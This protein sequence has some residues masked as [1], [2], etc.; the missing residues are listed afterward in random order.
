M[1]ELGDS[2]DIGCVNA[3]LEPFLRPRCRRTGRRLLGPRRSDDPRSPTPGFRSGAPARLT[4]RDAATSGGRGSH[5]EPRADQPGARSAPGKAMAKSAKQRV[6]EGTHRR[7][8]ERL[9]SL[10]ERSVDI[11]REWIREK[12][13]S[14]GRARQCPD[15]PLAQV[16]PGF[17]TSV[18]CIKNHVASS[19][20]KFG[21][22]W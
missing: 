20:A 16:L 7:Q 22:R 10:Q 5:A 18:F 4:P 8:G 17:A 9:P 19:R 21:S 13:N 6:E 2:S 14:R 12:E 3:G 15:P 1:R 11:V